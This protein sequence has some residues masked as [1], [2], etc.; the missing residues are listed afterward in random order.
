MSARRADAVS[1][2]SAIACRPDAR[3]EL[4]TMSDSESGERPKGNLFQRGLAKVGAALDATKEFSAEGIAAVTK[5]AG[6]MHAPLNAV[7]GDHLEEMGSPLALP[8]TLFTYRDSGFVAVDV[9]KETLS[10][11]ELP[12]SGHLCIFVHGLGSN[13]HTWMLRHRTER[14]SCV[15]RK[16]EQERGVASFFVR[17]NSGR[18]ISENGRRLSD[19]IE[20]LYTAYPQPVLSISLIGHSM[21]GLVV[22]SA[23]HYAVQEGR[24]WSGKL[25][26]NFLLGSPLLG[27]HQEQIGKLTSDILAVIPTMA[28]RLVARVAEA[29][30]AGIQ[31][32]RYGYLRDED[33]QE[34][35]TSEIT[36]LSSG[37]NRRAPVPLLPGVEY[38]LIVGSVHSDP[39]SIAAAFL[40]DGI[41]LR[42]SARASGGHQARYEDFA[43]ATVAEV[44]GLNHL[45]IP[46][47]LRVYRQLRSWLPRPA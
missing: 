1:V 13:Q 14:E 15:G 42:S 40:G 47:D 31:D 12:V 39:N 4:T 21:G 25:K 26:R 34:N 27:A 8:M 9:E 41:V 20:Q 36:G 33:W 18:H 44:A 46:G 32:L 16:L 19:L 3:H 2:R 10:A 24:A 6:K 17:Y 38:Y 43:G 29:R 35:P 22:R 5:V 7:V 11:L 37:E 30:S 23:C 28:T 45:D